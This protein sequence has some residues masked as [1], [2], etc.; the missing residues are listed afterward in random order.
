[1]NESDGTPEVSPAEAHAR[2][3]AGAIL[4]DV[5]EPGECALGSPLGALRVPLGRIVDGLAELGVEPGTPVLALCGGGTRSLKA[6]AALAEHGYARVASVAGGFRRWKREGLPFELVSTLDADARERYSR[7]LLLPEVGEAGQARL[8][9]ARVLVVGAGGL[10]SPVAYYLAAAGVGALRLVDDDLVDRSNLQR[11]ILHADARVGSPKVD[12]A[13]ATLVAL[14]PR[15]AIETHA[16]KL[17]EDNAD[18]LVA[19]CDVVVDGSDNFAARYAVDAACTRASVPLVYGAVHRY[20]GQ[21]G[22]FGVPGGPC[23]RCLFPEPPPPDAAPNCAEAG[24]LGVVPGLVG[25]VQATEAIKLL[26]G[27]G[28][29]LV[30]RLL[31]VDALA[32]RF[33]E[34][35]LPRDPDCPGCGPNPRAV[36]SPA[37]AC[38]T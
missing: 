3:A 19:A 11:Q 24:V 21:V 30:G 27:I 1:M 29:P 5:R 23:Y 34:L 32:M 8:A 25:L 18:A 4:V 14:N 17:D 16:V 36:G 28:E 31:H 2:V 22:V 12:S 35:R 15:V 20:E 13:A 26:L 9:R 7:H 33:R 6:A 37:P 38:A 10:G